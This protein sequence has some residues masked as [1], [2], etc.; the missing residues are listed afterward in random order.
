MK[1]NNQDFLELREELA[2]VEHERWAHW[3][4]Y[5]HSKCVENG[6]G[7]LTIPKDLVE[8][9]TRQSKTAFEN[10]TAKEKESDREQVDKYLP[11][12]KKFIKNGEV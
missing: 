9:W 11:I 6:D 12:L 7:S 1:Y 10:L 8:Q 5:M 4:I 3:Q 2:A